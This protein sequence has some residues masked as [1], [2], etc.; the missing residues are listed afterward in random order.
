VP[1]GPAY[2]ACYHNWKRHVVQARQIAA[3]V[4]PD[5]EASVSSERSDRFYVRCAR[6]RLRVLDGEKRDQF[7]DDL[8]GFLLIG[9]SGLF[10]LMLAAFII[11]SFWRVRKINK[12]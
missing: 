2:A 4:L 7:P 10:V 1:P 5:S 12:T 8:Q 6:G 3:A 11:S 9:A